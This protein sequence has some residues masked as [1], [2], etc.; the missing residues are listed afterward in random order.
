MAF[1]LSIRDWT[2][3]TNLNEINEIEKEYDLKI[4]VKQD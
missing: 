3:A 2:E 4:N 1:L